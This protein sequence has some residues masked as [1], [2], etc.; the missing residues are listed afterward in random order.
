MP[1]YRDV[2]GYSGKWAITEHGVMANKHH[3]NAKSRHNSFIP[4]G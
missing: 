3:P 2:G 1:A 4:A